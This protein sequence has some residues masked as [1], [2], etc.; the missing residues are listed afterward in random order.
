MLC[1][2]LDAHVAWAL[3][4][5]LRRR[6][7]GISVW[8]VGQAHMP[9]LDTPDPEILVWCETHGCILVTNNRKSMPGHLADHLRAGRHIPGIFTL[10]SSMSLGET[11]Q[12]LIDAAQISLEDEYR[13]Q[14]RHLPL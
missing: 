13:D 2:L 12:N 4:F 9:P 14:I 10:N 8:R 11:I 3:L 1:Y 6:E 5:G 7:P